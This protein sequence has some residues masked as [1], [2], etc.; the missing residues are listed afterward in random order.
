VTD[1]ELA[2]T[3]TTRLIRTLGLG[4][5]AA[6]GLLSLLVLAD[7]LIIGLHLSMKFLGEP[8]EYTFDLG[9]DRGFGEF[10][11]YL[12]IAWAAMMLLILA[13]RTRVGVYAAWA[14][15]CIF[16]AADDG[17]QLHE[18]AG[19]ATMA[20]FPE[21]GT[22]AI[23]LGELAWTAAV[24]AVLVA[25][26]SI[27]HWRAAAGARAISLVI[28]A[29]FGVLIFFGVVLD[30][31]HHIFLEYPAFD[32]PMTTIEDGGEIVAMS[33]MVV[34]LFAVTFAGHGPSD[35][36]RGRQRAGRVKR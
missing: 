32:V 1:T 24:G 4:E 18:Q 25:I 26:V 19:F 11:Q 2:T 10:F 31:I 13:A 6:R 22:L 36:R 15:V 20:A 3:R 16:F 27:A 34:F 8:Q 7:V 23:H 33:L 35:R 5:P 28:A 30:G 9:A 12:Q 17:L 21:L 14:L 29:L